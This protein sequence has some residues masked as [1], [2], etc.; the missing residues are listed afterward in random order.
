MTRTT[1]VHTVPR[2]FA[3]LRLRA[4]MTQQ[5]VA[6]AT[7]GEVGVKTYFTF[8]SGQRIESMKVCQFEAIVQALGMTVVDFIEWTPSFSEYRDAGLLKGQRLM[9][10]R[11]IDIDGEKREADFWPRSTP[12]GWDS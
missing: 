9:A 1:F 11:R 8:E 4:G 6:D 2:K 3:L 10:N 12:L 5:Q 7:R